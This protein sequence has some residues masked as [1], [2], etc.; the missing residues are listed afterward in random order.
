MKR[1]STRRSA[2]YATATVL[3]LLATSAPALAVTPSADTAASGGPG[4]ASYFDLARKDC[5]GTARD[6]TSKV[7][8]T[9]AGGVLSDVYEPTIDNTNVSTLQYVVTDGSTFTALQTRDMTYTARADETGMVCTVTSTDAKHGY[10]LTTTYLTDPSRDSVLMNTRL[11]PTPGST[12]DVRGLH[13]F[14]RLDAHV[15]GN[16]G[17]GTDNAGAD[18]GVIDARSGVPVVYDTSTVSEAANRDYAVPT[19]MALTADSADSASVGYAGT[20][21][22]GLTQLD[23]THSLTPA[24]SAPA[25][26]IVA[27]E[28]VTPAHGRDFTLSLGFGRTQAAAVSTASNSL[29]TPFDAVE[30]SYTE[31]WRGYDHSLNPAPRGVSGIDP[32]TVGRTY[33]L[34]AN[35]LKAS[36]DKTF[37][38][39][40]VA[41]LASPWGQAVNAGASVNGKAAYFGSYREV[42]ARDLYEAFTGLLA[43][44]DLATARATARFLLEKQ[45]RTDGQLP[46]NSLVN[47]LSAPDTGGDQLDETA[48]PI[49][50]AYLS[51]IGGD[52]ALWSQ[53]VKPAADFL[54]SHGPSFGVERWEEQSGYS[55][56]TIAAEIAGLTAAAAI[57]TRHGDRADAAVYQATADDFQRHI[58]DWTVTSTGP[59]SSNPYFIRLS[60]SGDPNAATSYYLG[61]GGP[62]LD[63]RTVIDGGF[64]ELVRLGELSPADAT[65]L[66]SLSVLDRQISV[67]TS[68]GTGYY[69]YGNA[70]ASGSADGYGDCSTTNSQTSCTLSGQ[71]WPTTDVGTGHLWPVLS[72]ERAES[73]LA[74]GDPAQASALLAFMIKSASGVGLVPEQVWEDPN[75][76]ASPYGSDPATASIGFANGHA[77]G[78][79]SPLTW[80]QAQ[81]LRLIVDLGTNQTVDKPAI[82]TER[83]ATHGASAAVTVT[84]TTPASGSTIE[85]GS[86]TVTGTTSPGASVTIAS[87]DTDTGAPASTTTT[88]ADATGAFTASVSVGFGTNILTAAA[89]TAAGATG[90]A[91]TAVVGDVVGGTT[92]LDVTDPAGDDDGP[93]TYQ[94]P[95]S[96][97]FSA[98]SFD[99]TRFQVI[100]ANGTVYLRTTLAKLTPT[101]GNVM[102]AQLL[103]VYVHNPTA[104]STSTAAAYPSRNY[105][106]A[107][108]DAWSQR[109]EVQGFASPV[110]TDPN[111][112]QVGTPTAVVASTVPNTITIALPEAAFGTP[113][114]GWTFTVALTGQDG[115]SSDQARAFTPTP[116]DYSFGICAAGGGEPICSVAP[117][118]VPEVMDT[119]TPQ[120]VSQSTE[121]DPTLGPV[122]LHGVTAP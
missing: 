59:D 54:V 51:G 40:I 60:K 34:D 105:T 56:S 108:P 57:A 101:F 29:R 114:A 2:A 67:T 15:N 45:Q 24:S 119:V 102:G 21:S 97:S 64:Q 20:A 107:G 83:Y 8:Y 90:Y 88:T 47:G 78:S 30:A 115:F 111:G 18:T 72:G 98:G 33:L 49:L 94:Y 38:G 118:T 116:G 85:G 6:T 76:P 13:V 110:W 91:Q 28:D 80:A 112:T 25:G 75:L 26:H 5:V 35:V 86:T 100:T 36:E 82:T 120:G 58:K 7:W 73:A 65:F 113:A 4:A 1:T 9:V 121:L 99:L 117:N 48:Y 81:E 109:L 103:D 53:H 106:V 79:A 69:R 41:S 12:T 27:T 61:N 104:T 71:P 89:T 70:A 19:Y 10:Q 46:R 77:A 74:E 68:T 32:Q 23:A 92:V 16:G 63:Q 122:I 37:P 62:T 52:A 95:T 84:L 87:D 11:S 50:M 17:G 43:D 14:A 96:S 39:A 42:F 22:D 55:V 66:N 31:G 3:A 93:G 44:G